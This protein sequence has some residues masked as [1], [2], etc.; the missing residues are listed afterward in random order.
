MKRGGFVRDAVLAHGI[1]HHV[2][3]LLRSDQSINKSQLVIRMHVVVVRA[4]DDQ[5]MAVQLFG[6]WD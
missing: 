5:E 6:K 4:E 1:R 3:S 2:E